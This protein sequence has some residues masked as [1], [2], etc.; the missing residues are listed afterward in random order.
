M[1]RKTGIYRAFKGQGMHYKLQ[2]TR[3]SYTGWAWMFGH[4][5]L[6]STHLGTGCLQSTW[7]YLTVNQQHGSHRH[8]PMSLGNFFTPW[9]FYRNIISVSHSLDL[10]LS[11]SVSLWVSELLQ[12]AQRLLDWHPDI[13]PA[14]KQS[15]SFYFQQT[16]SLFDKEQKLCEGNVNL[17]TW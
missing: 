12:S 5:E 11:F 17:L 13:F 7:A 16:L 2:D 8:I 10:S 14:R 1:F 9:V 15:T 4:G 3:H 6:R